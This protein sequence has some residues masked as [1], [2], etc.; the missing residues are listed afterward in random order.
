MTLN[1]TTRR[2]YTLVEMVV[3]LGIL[4]L[5]LGSLASITVL[6]TRALPSSSDPATSV[7]SAERLAALFASDVETA[8]SFSLVGETQVNFTVP[9]RDDDGVEE[10]VSYAWAGGGGAVSRTLNNG[11]SETLIGSVADLEFWYDG[12]SGS[13]GGVRE[14]HSGSALETSG[15]LGDS[16]LWYALRIDPSLPDGTAWSLTG[17]DIML[18]KSSGATGDVVVAARADKSGSVAAGDLDRQEVSVGSIGTS[19]GAV[20]VGLSAGPFAAD[21]AC[22][23]VVGG[24]DGSG[25]KELG[26]ALGKGSTAVMYSSDGGD[27]WGAV[28]ADICIDAYGTTDTNS[29]RV[30]RVV[31]TIVPLVGADATI[32]TAVEVLNKP[33][34][35]G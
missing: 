15:S 6:M 19:W 32:R 4:S 30:E 21:D 16:Q 33:E 26:G 13:G 18:K 35:G 7:M 27:S 17:V 31:L 1:R 2:A 8:T 9:D 22:W 12:I 25:S 34:L 3:S 23:I 11:T 20:F 24:S 29:G 28:E 5:V 14:L 10:K